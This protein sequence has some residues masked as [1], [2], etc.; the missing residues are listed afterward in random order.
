MYVRGDVIKGVLTVKIFIGIPS[1]PWEFL[2]FGDLIIFSI[3]FSVVYFS[4]M[5]EQGSLKF[6]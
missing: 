1:Y 3:S 2:D 6:V 5:F 4:F